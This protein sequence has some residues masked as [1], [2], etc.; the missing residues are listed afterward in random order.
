M[1][2]NEARN[3]M[4]EM[5]LRDLNA[6][7]KKLADDP[8]VPDGLRAE[9]REMVAEFNADAQGLVR[10]NAAEHYWGAELMVR[11]ARFLP[12]VLEVHSTPA[13]ARG[14]LQE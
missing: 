1:G 13:D 7:C 11:M 4:K 10:G 3:A 2:A 14:I 8:V 12:R 5:V 6:I 9:A